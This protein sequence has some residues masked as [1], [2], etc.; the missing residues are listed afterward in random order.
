MHPDA[1]VREP[2]EPLHPRASVARPAGHG[3]H[4]GA[5]AR[6]HHATAP[7]HEFA[8]DARAVCRDRRWRTDESSVVGKGFEVLSAM[9][10]AAR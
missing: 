3:V 1:T 6:A 4:F 2:H 10:G 9:A 7:V 5:D 8:I